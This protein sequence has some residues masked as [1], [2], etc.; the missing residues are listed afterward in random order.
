MDI[1]P[2]RPD[3]EYVD[4]EWFEGSVE[5]GPDAD[6]FL[7]RVRELGPTEL[8]DL[9]EPDDTGAVPYGCV[10]T[11]EVPGVPGSEWPVYTHML[12]VMY[13]PGLLGGYWGCSHLWD[14]YDADDPEALHVPEELTAEQA[15]VRA[16]RWLAEQLRRPL[17]R[18]EWD[19]RWYGVGSSRWVLTDT[20]RVVAG[21]TRP[22]RRR[23]DPDRVVPLRG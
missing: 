2:T 20:G 18:Q 16:V 13:A 23:P 12:Q 21:R 9:V 1:R 6:A 4:A 3:A 22:P 17:L 8:G 15:A 7:A 11:V 14:D 19:G 10:L 5:G